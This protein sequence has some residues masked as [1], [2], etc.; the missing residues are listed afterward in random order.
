MKYYAVYILTNQRHSVL[1]TGVTSYLQKRLSEHKRK[2]NPRSFTSRYNV[3]KLVHL[4]WFPS[5]E[6]AILREKQIKKRSRA[7]KLR[8]INDSNPEWRDLSNEI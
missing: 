6:Q 7:Y 8:L 1:Y 2:V 4:E 3:E 5:M